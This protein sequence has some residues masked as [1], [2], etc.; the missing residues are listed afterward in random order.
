MINA[1]HTHCAP[2]GYSHYPLYNTSIPGFIIEVYE[3]LVDGI[4][5]SILDAEKNK[6]TGKIYFGNGSF[7]PE[8]PVSFNR[9]IK[10]Y[11]QN[12]DVEKVSY[13]NRHLAVDRNMDLL[14]FVADDGTPIGSINWFSV[15]TTNLPNTFLRLCSDNKGFA[16][17]YFEEDMFSTNPN[18]HASFA[19]GSCGDVSARYIYNPKLSFQRGKYEGKYSNDLKSSQYNGQLQFDKAKQIFQDTKTENDCGSELDCGIL[20]VDMGHVNIEPKFADGQDGCLT[21][22]ACMGSIIF[23]RIE[24]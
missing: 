17:T 11:N 2:G 18:F 24:V 4:V 10:A 5:T 22:P 16:A 1:Q 8:I 14:K 7:E 23:G 15:H 21:S 12:K 19:Q 6:R 13:E 20:Y 9:S 3:E